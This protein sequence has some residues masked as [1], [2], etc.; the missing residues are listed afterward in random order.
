MSSFAT[1]FQVAFLV[2]IVSEIF[3]LFLSNRKN[4]M[5]VNESL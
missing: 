4:Y 2:N 1:F 3:A 5:L